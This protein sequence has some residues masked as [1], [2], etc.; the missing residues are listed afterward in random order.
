MPFG[1]VPDNT[2][3]I[4]IVPTLSLLP[5]EERSVIMHSQNFGYLCSRELS[6][7]RRFSHLGIRDAL[8][9]C[10]FHCLPGVE[11]PAWRVHRRRW[12]HRS[13]GSRWGRREPSEGLWIPRNCFFQ[14]SI[15]KHFG[16]FTSS[17]VGSAR[18]S[19]VFRL[20]FFLSRGKESHP[21][22]APWEVCPFPV[23]CSPGRPGVHGLGKLRD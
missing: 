11:G 6:A 13:H 8:S 21:C 17:V 2:W 9:V 7:C 1:K 12:E 10:V 19:V 14:G 15:P 4:T 16:H 3:D 20:G 22:P 5:G 23:P 18:S